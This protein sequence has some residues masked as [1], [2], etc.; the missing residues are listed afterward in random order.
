MDGAERNRY[1]EAFGFPAAMAELPM[2]CVFEECECVGAIV[3]RAMNR[4]AGSPNRTLGTLPNLPPAKPCPKLLPPF[5]EAAS[6]RNPHSIPEPLSD[7]TFLVPPPLTSSPCP[8]CPPAPA[9]CEKTLKNIP[10][11]NAVF[12]ALG[13]EI[14]E[15]GGVM[16]IQIRSVASLTTTRVSKP[17]PSPS[18]NP[19]RPNA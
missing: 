14:Q 2:S 9:V 8:V 1:R 18:P 13:M 19:T 12:L 10:A 16:K 3:P 15:N 7:E 6:P 17:N 4:H 5:P 11:L